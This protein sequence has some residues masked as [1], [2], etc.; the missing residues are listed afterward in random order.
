MPLYD[1]RTNRHRGGADSAHLVV[2][3]APPNMSLMMPLGS[4]IL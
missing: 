4:V 3:P 2:N 1:R